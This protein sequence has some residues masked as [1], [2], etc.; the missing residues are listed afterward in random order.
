M[1]RQAKKQQRFSSLPEPK[2]SAKEVKI[3]ELPQ[4]S[5]EAFSLA[6]IDA[7]ATKGIH[8]LKLN[9]NIAENATHNQICQLDNLQPNNCRCIGELLSAS[10]IC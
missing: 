6:Y 5:L 1:N 2:I 9:W 4:K 8:W 10:S 7:L 3:T